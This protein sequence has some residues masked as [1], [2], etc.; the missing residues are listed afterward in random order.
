MNTI[1]G[2]VEHIDTLLWCALALTIGMVPIKLYASYI[3]RRDTEKKP[4][5]K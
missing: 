4:K 5:G 3:T 2:M 1:L